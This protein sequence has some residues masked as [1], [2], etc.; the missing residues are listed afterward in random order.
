ILGGDLSVETGSA[1]LP[2]AL[3]AWLRARGARL[4]HVVQF[5]SMLR[6]PGHRSLLVAVKAVDGAWP[7][8]GH[9]AF[10]PPMR[11]AAATR[12]FGLVTESIVAQRLGLKPGAIVHLGAAGFTYRGLISEEPDRIASPGILGGRVLIATAALPATKL[13]VPGALVDFTLR[14]AF[15]AGTN[16]P[17]VERAL[18]AAF[19]GQGWRIRDAA[20]AAP[21]VQRFLDR[22]SIFMTLVGLT[23]LLVGGIGVANGV[24]AW[25][26]G[27]ARSI[28]TLRCL[29][30][31]A[32]LIAG[33]YAVQLLALCSLGILAGLAAGAVLPLVAASL[34][35]N[36]LPVP[37]V[38]GIYWAPL[39]LA[40]L[41][42]LLT[43][44]S[45]ALWPLAR[46]ARIP[47]AALFRDA[48]L[49]ASIRPTPPLLAVQAALVAALV[50]LTVAAAPEPRFAL[51]F[52]AGAAA[53]LLVF[54]LGA[55]ALVGIARALPRPTLAWAQ[56]GVGNLHRPRS[57]VA[58]MLVSV[59]LGLTT[60]AAVALIEGNIRH[61][62]GQQMPGEAPSFFFIDIQTAELQPFLGLLH[63]Q[64]G[65]QSIA[66]AP[67]LRARVVAVN[68]V[69][70][71]QVHATADT[72]WALRGDR[73]LTY[74]ATPPPG[75]KLVA[76]SWWPAAY[77][78]P[79]LVSFDAH[80]AQGWGVKLGGTITVNVLGRDIVLRVASLR[81]IAWQSLSLNY[82]MIA[83]PG[84]L[85]GAPHTTIATV[86]VAP[87][88]QGAVLRAVSD[89]L[90]NVTGIRVA[91]V[92][93]AVAALLS[94]LGA[95][96]AGLGGLALA[97]GALVLT[98]AV[99]AGQQ[100]RVGEAVILKTLG[101]TRAQIRAA[102]LV[103]FGIVGAAAG[104][105]AAAI[106]TAGAFVVVRYVFFA[107]WHFQ[108]AILAATVAGSVA[109]MLLFGF[110]G[111]EAAL[112]AKAAPRLRNE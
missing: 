102:W 112:R 35:K 41:F 62:I 89:A 3:D 111:T 29:G 69:P 28:A 23:A 78:G 87:P 7:L 101:A 94:Q 19:P 81:R 92:L 50:A 110:A 65:V 17:K 56:L 24:Q 16:V 97:A 63:R 98:G 14:A 45:F 93:Q 82:A 60:L 106:G 68:G 73:G 43:A 42:G 38:E 80:L 6:A 4:S 9:A 66:Y 72:R 48:V 15:P 21:E 58:L 64:T 99:A 84:L 108:P 53:T 37:P 104:L 70:A 27:R 44:A 5:R 54:R 86:R 105:I 47:G 71:A 96:V 10:A 11:P 46:A 13:I 25:L 33:S 76:G 77:A 79:P 100:R 55:A 40:A 83:S 2:A 109:L 39:G 95:A 31:S 75:T 74:A 18:H 90:P 59:G 1:L 8:V 22:T 61:E 91:D 49:P 12:G 20:H 32:R 67:N 85:S 34:L 103:E 36:V 51:W 26:Q 57:G 52:C 88:D 30:A 107:P